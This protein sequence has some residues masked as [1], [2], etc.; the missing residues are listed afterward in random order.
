MFFKKELLAGLLAL[1]FLVMPMGAVAEDGVVYIIDS[2]K[3]YDYKLWE[4]VGR[5]DQKVFE[6]GFRLLNE[7]K[8]P[9]NVRFTLKRN[10]KETN[11]YAKYSRGEIAIYTGMLLYIQ[12]DDELAAILAH[13]MGHINQLSTGFWPWK[14]T[15]MWFAPKFYEFDADKIGIDYMVKAGYNPLAMI[16]VFNKVGPE[17]SNFYKFLLFYKSLKTLYYKILLT[18]NF[19]DILLV[20][21][22]DTHPKTSKRMDKI[23]NHILVN[24]PN[25]ITEG[26]KNPYYANFLMNAE[27]NTD[28]K[29]IREKH[30][31]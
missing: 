16:T 9:K 19:I 29:I 15:K 13:E 5:Y 23:Y 6:V 27:K 7:N 21:P 11:A 31:L 10:I 2:N 14:R 17:D 3:P 8:F 4:R 28:I 26:Y 22:Y 30:D 20:R 25:F 12:N 1:C 24:Y 18:D